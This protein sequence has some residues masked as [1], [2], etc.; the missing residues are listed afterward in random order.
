VAVGSTDQQQGYIVNILELQTRLAELNAE[1]HQI[2]A[3]A[4]AEKRDL[5]V[6]ETG[7]LDACLSQFDRVKGDVDRLQRLGEQTEI[8]NAPNGRKTEPDAPGHTEPREEQPGHTESRK[9][10]RE[11]PRVPARYH[12]GP[13]NGGFRT[14]GE[15][16]ISVRHACQKR[17]GAID[18]RLEALAS[19]TTYGSEGSGSD[20]GFAVPPDFRSAIMETILGEESLLARCDQVPVDGNNFTCPVDETSPW[21]TTGGIQAYWDGEA[22]AATQSKPQLNE[23][24]TKLNKLRALVPMTEELLEDASATDAYLKR[25]APEKIAFKINYALIQGT[26]VGMPLGIL[27]CPATVSVAKE[28]GQ[29]TGTIIGMNIFRMYNRMYGPCRSKGVWIYNQ[30][31]EPQLFKLSIPGTDDTGNFAT[32]WGGLLYMPAGGVSGQPYGTIFGRPC[33]PS[34]ACS[35]LSTVGDILFVDF[36]QYLA[37]LKS[38]PNPRVD[39]SMH[40]WFDQDLVAYKFTLR[41]GGVPWWS[42]AVSPLNGSNTY[43]PY[44]SLATR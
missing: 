8:L 32:N 25:K 16:A 20:G 35:A 44:V 23:R 29:Q 39:V 17:G 27:N 31:V 19:A 34:Q 15:M 21:Q 14:L 40:L 2:K 7:Q 4:E 36:S 11:E 28:S 37:L 26:G 13:K 41:M 18:P 43:S 9:L 30:E 5:S 6:E 1:A 24:T 3:K 10:S 22:A 33:V 38:G 12:T 42:A